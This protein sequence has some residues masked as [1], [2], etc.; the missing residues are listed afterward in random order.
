MPA[1]F[2]QTVE[3]VNAALLSVPM[4]VALLCIGLLFTLWSGFCQYRSLT[5]GLAL[6]AGRGIDTSH[7]A[8]AL[9]HFQ[10]LTTAMSGTVGL[11]AIAG[12]AIAVDFGG[13]GAVFWMWMVGL[14]GM[15]LKTTEVTLALLYRDTSEPGN[16]HGGTMYVARDGLG[17]IYPR[18]LGFGRFVGGFFACALLLF[19][20]TGGNMF[21]T[22][23]AA[24]TTREYF[25][26]PT[27]A[28]GIILAV[29]AGVVLLGGIRRI[30]GV[31]RLLVPLKCGVYV[32]CGLYVI[33]L[34]AQELPHLLRLI[35]V[36]AFSA[37]QAAGAF[38]GGVMG[39]AF[40]WGMKRALFSSESGLGTAPIAHAAV[41]T[42]EPVTEGVVAGLEPFIDTM[43]VC[44][45]T[46]LVILC[47]GVWNRA[48]AARWE[49]P[50]TFVQTGPGQ[51][52]PDLVQPP[53][54]DPA[55]SDGAPLFAVADVG[56][57][58]SRVYGTVQRR[59]DRREIAWQPVA[60][61]TAPR[62]LE[63]GLFADYRGATLVAKSFDTVHE[64]FGRW[65]I[66][67]AV[68]AFALSTVISY[69]YYG[70]QGVIY[71]FGDAAVRPFRWLWCFAAAAA[72]FGFI[73]TSVQLDALSTVGMG[74]MYLV[75]L[76]LMLLLGGRA[77]QAYRDYFARLR[78]GLV[79]R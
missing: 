47:S 27:W 77:M 13:P 20:V 50:P 9:S 34:H 15:A 35:V 76:P 48:P 3:A 78:A 17:R 36:S 73:R 55:W 24:D 22:W 52:A 12:M 5:H 1:G 56:G 14:L 71:L 16:P 74:F 41:K 63:P 44:T 11:G 37:T 58:R 8:G 70:E 6:C 21:Q 7:G 54:A 64:G 30:G 61:A 29:L 4:L 62:M 19:A 59:H 72:C 69:G 26:V 53:A 23:S 31:T 18:L 43:F 39:S 2:W 40:M 57:K 79:R 67:L 38:T 46:G 49:T 28:S 42:P 45:V 33:L 51:W 75:N 32:V 65:L 60:A 66:T 10:A 25:G 68:W